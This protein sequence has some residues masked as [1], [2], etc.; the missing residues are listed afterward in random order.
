[1]S[2]TSDEQFVAESWEAQEEHIIT[3]FDFPITQISP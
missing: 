3:G 2:N 1:M